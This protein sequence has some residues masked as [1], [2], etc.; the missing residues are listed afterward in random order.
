MNSDFENEEYDE[1]D[2]KIDKA[3]LIKHEI[4]KIEDCIQRLGGIQSC[5]WD[6]ADH[7]DFL[8]I[9]TKHNDKV[10][11][12]AFLTDMKRAV[13]TADEESI[14]AHIQ[15]FQ[16]VQELIERKKKLL[17]DYKEVKKE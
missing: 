1:E 8:R 17:Q 2:V 3:E 4:E 16:N 9:R 10:K 7:K 13:P 14:K 11:T 12:V 5:G 15:T 6:H